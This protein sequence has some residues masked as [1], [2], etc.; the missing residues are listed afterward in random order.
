MADEITADAIRET[1]TASFMKRREG[2]VQLKA[3]QMIALELLQ[4]A[5]KDLEGFAK[6][7]TAKKNISQVGM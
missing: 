5:W 4:D 1:L 6:K 7:E 3:A 2:D